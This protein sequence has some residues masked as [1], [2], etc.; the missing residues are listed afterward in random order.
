MTMFDPKKRYADGDRSPVPVAIYPLRIRKVEKRQSKKQGGGF[1]LNLELDIVSGD[2]KTRRLW[3]IQ[4]LKLN[5]DMV[6]DRFANLILSTGHTEEF[7]PEDM[8]VLHKILDGAVVRA[9]VTQTEYKS[10]DLDEDGNPI[11][12]TKNEIESFMEATE[13]DRINADDM[14][15]VDD[16]GSSSGMSGSGGMK[17]KDLGDIPFGG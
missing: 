11:M 2:F 5:I 12:K 16:G 8:G 14:D 6:A 15:P 3:H 9:N 13:Q 4:S 1:Y 17:K 7:D 10:R